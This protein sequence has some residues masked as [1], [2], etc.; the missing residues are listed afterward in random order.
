MTRDLSL[1][2][3]AP[4]ERA[5][6]MCGYGGR[7][8]AW[9]RL[10]DRQRIPFHRVGHLRFYRITDLECT[11]DRIDTAAVRRFTRAS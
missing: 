8:R 11:F 6:A 5:A 3:W 2:R 10:A 7:V 9:R 1:L 4:T